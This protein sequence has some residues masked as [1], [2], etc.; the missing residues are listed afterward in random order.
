VVKEAVGTFAAAADQKHLQLR[1]R[2][3]E[4][5]PDSLMGDPIA[6]RQ[7]LTN[8]LGNAIKF[9]EAGS[10]EVSV[11]VSQPAL[12]AVTLEFEVADSGIGI[13]PDRLDRIFEEFTQATYETGVKFGGSGLGLAIS[14]K[15]LALYGSRIQV[16][17]TPGEGSTFSFSLRLATPPATAA[18]TAGP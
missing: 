16:V 5:V 2:I 6:L 10:V 13:P 15:L 11:R 1:S 14:R 3:D 18:A 4:L 7:I 9:T 17:S 12:D 8:L